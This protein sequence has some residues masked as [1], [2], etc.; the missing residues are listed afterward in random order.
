MKKFSSMLALALAM[1]LTLGMTVSAAGS[2][3]TGSTDVA[4]KVIVDNSTVTEEVKTD[5]A[6]PEKLEAAE[7]AALA[8][9][10]LVLKDNFKAPVEVTK[11]Y[12]ASIKEKY[13]LPDEAVPTVTINP[14]AP[15]VQK[16]AQEAAVALTN[17][18]K[19]V[20]LPAGK[21]AADVTVLKAAVDIDFTI[22]GVEES[23]VE[24]IKK[25]GVKLAL[26]I[27]VTP[28]EGKV[29][30]IAHMYAPGKWETVPAN[31]TADGTVIATFYSFSPVYV[32]EVDVA[33]KDNGND[34]D[35]DDDAQQTAPV[36]ETTASPK[37]G[38]ALPVAGVMAVICL[39]GAAVCTAKKVKFNN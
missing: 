22:T 8:T 10:T 25:A 20:A 13:N 12:A 21:T 16:I 34:S 32:V 29:Y 27:K 3:S 35:D 18:L 26:P 24:E 5:V 23:K 4:D 38:E 30:Y 7:E 1:A 37:T 36:E 31:I 15:E 2:T 9:E 39:I 19:S 33:V 14:V 11:D 17:N 28:V 6:L